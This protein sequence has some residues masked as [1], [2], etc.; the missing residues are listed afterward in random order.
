MTT[1]NQIFDYTVTADQALL[2]QYNEA[3]N[4]Q[5]LIELKQAWYNT[6][7]SAFWKSWFNNV[8]WLYNPAPIT[9]PPNPPNPEAFSQFGAIVWS[10]ILGVQ[11]TIGPPPDPMGK[12]I[13]GF[14]TNPNFDNGNFTNGGTSIGE[15]LL[16]Q[17]IILK[18]RYFQLTNRGAIP[19]INA[20]IGPLLEGFDGYPGR[21]Y[22]LD[23]L[24]MTMTYVFTTA[25]P[26]SIQYIIDNYDIF[27]RPAGVGV[28]FIVDIQ[29]IFGF[30]SF[31]QN[32]DQGCFSAYVP[33]S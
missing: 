21:V 3:T 14:D 23:N 13:W 10:L 7:Q 1:R 32:F 4:L 25:I 28:N 11:L 22:V 31:N 16:L 26:A 20:F 18:L 15:S 5:T 33:S 12:P 2:W 17:I 27:P 29:A 6:Y 24:N 8:F 30:D 9:E 19:E